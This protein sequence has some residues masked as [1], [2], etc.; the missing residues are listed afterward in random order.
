MAY[1][2]HRSAEL[3]R[4]ACSS[5]Q[6]TAATGRQA[7]GCGVAAGS[8]ACLGPRGELSAAAAPSSNGTCGDDGGMMIYWLPLVRRQQFVTHAPQLPSA[9]L[10]VRAGPPPPGA[11][12]A[13]VSRL[14][15]ST[16]GDSTSRRQTWTSCLQT[17]FLSSHRRESP[18]RS[19]GSDGKDKEARARWRGRGRSQS[20]SLLARSSAVQDTGEKRHL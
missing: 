4:E 18:A 7:P 14:P 20:V 1:S 15:V 13:G 6:P 3:A 5:Q 12:W 11:D 9:L 19:R 2:S 16:A 8:I 10:V 17:P